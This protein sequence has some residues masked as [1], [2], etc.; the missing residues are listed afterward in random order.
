L[1]HTVAAASGAPYSVAVKA[2]EFIYVSGT[3]A[4]DN[5]DCT[6]VAARDV[7]AQTRYVIERM[8][9]VLAAAGSSL[10]QV[11][12]VTVFLRSQADFAAMNDVYRTFWPTD[13]PTRTTVV[14]DLVLPDALVEMSMTAVG[15]GVERTIV[16]PDGWLKSPSPY[17]YAIRTGETLFLSGLVS[18][19]GRD[20]SMVPGDVAAQTR[21]VLENA[22]ELLRAAGMTHANVVSSKIYLPDLETFQQMNGAYRTFFPSAPPARATVGAGL[23]GAQYNVEITMIASAAP[24]HVVDD[25]RPVNPNLSAAIVAGNRVYVSGMLGNTESNQTDVAAQTR[26]TLSRIGQA[27]ESAGSSPAD[28]VEGVVYLT[29]LGDYAAMNDAYRAFFGRDF[30]AR[31]TIRSGLVVPDGLVEIMVVAE[32]GAGRR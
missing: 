29:D 13:P 8:R 24:R 25:R 21:T 5:T 16:H 28:V 31:V 15:P 27:L 9:D 17:S 11:V 30:P 26:E 4:S 7:G 14:T 18:R 1:K 32:R 3:L 10:S 6:H 23:A 22:G 19:N 2:G 12:S 20:N